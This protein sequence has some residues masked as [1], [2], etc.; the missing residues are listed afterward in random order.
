V[1]YS[2]IIPAHNEAERL[3]DSSER[4]KVGLDF[5][6]RDDC[7]VIL[8]DDGSSDGT[9]VVAAQILRDLPHSMVI[10]RESNH[11]K[12]AAIRLG[13][14]AASGD[15]VFTCDADMAVTA[16]NRL[17]GSGRADAGRRPADAIEP[18]PEWA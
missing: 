8:I 18:P 4:L 14:A 6:G 7:E 3:G 9:G 16:P 17:A 13:I 15:H 12:G 10:R 11:G 2:I 1:K 5:L